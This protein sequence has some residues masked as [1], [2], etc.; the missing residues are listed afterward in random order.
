MRITAIAAFA[1][2]I[3]SP[4]FGGIYQDCEEAIK[5]GDQ[6]RA[7]ELSETIE[8]FTNITSPKDQ[9]AGAACFTFATG[10][11]HVFSLQLGT[12]V[13]SDEEGELILETQ[14]Q[15]AEEQRKQEQLAAERLAGELAQEARIVEIESLRIERIQTVWAAVGAAC[16]TLYDDDPVEAL[17]SKT[18]IDVFL[19]TGLPE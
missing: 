13:P 7:Q 11:P 12:F 9:V 6:K 4:C 8:R 17:T 5:A 2:I 19:E 10:E 3:G 1:A 14:K 15:L 16:F 18:C